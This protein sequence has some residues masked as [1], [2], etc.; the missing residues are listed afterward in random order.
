MGWG[1]GGRATCRK[2]L[3]SRRGAP[4]ASG[5]K[6]IDGK[7]PAKKSLFQNDDAQT[8][9]KKKF[10][11]LAIFPVSEKADGDRV[12]DDVASDDRFDGD[13]DGVRRRVFLRRK[14]W[15]GT[16]ASPQVRD[17]RAP[18]SF[19]RRRDG[20]ATD[21]D[22][23]VNVVAPTGMVEQSV[24]GDRGSTTAHQGR[25][26]EDVKHFPPRDCDE[27]D[28]RWYLRG[29]RRGIHF[30]PFLKHSPREKKKKL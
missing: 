27:R 8:N 9:Q 4:R 21:D 29:G 7:G 30:E 11:V 13:A 28:W 12:E 19:Y 10:G 22:A 18:Y 20:L 23:D 26:I 17:V 2:G 5:C 15:N 25:I 6:G 24:D 1:V 16:R 14:F 3:P